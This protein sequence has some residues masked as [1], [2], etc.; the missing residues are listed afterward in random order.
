[1]PDSFLPAIGA[2]RS[3]AAA[4][5]GGHVTPVPASQRVATNHSA[6]LQEL[7]PLDLQDTKTDHRLTLVVVMYKI[8]RRGI[9]YTVTQKMFEEWLNDQY[10]K[11]QLA[12][13]AKQVLEESAKTSSEIMAVKKAFETIQEKGAHG[14]E[15]YAA[16]DYVSIQLSAQ[17]IDTSL[18]EFFE[19]IKDALSDSI[20]DIELGD[21]AAAATNVVDSIPYLGVITASVKMGVK[22]IQIGLLIKEA[23]K[24]DKMQVT[25]LS[26]LETE[27]LTAV[28]YFQKRAG[29]KLGKDFSFAGA[30]VITS[31]VGGGA[32]VASAHALV[33]FLMNVTIRIVDLLHAT[34][35]NDWLNKKNLDL[36][37][38][39][40]ASVLGLHIPHLPELSLLELTGL[41]P[42]GWKKSGEDLP[43]LKEAVAAAIK[44]Q[45]EAAQHWLTKGAIKWDKGNY[46]STLSNPPKPSGDQARDWQAKQWS[47]EYER[48]L[49]LYSV[50]DKYL[51]TQGLRLYKGRTLVHDPQETG[52]VAEIK[53]RTIDSLKNMLPSI[54]PK[55]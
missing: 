28:T 47:K 21:I 44:E 31:L 27:T 10:G 24:V 9:N 8:R 5:N 52:I 4:T 16:N 25:S 49:F 53:A 33:T 51:L 17:A 43:L 42:V 39:R 38:F 23:L 29:L 34:R 32:I 20:T 46:Q 36:D 13:G 18:G 1:M 45:G 11:T 40:S 12:S 54:S 14:G 26:V 55:S 50:T 19:A 37:K 6:A 48:I 3:S 15:S 2:K 41:L 22:G 35:A 7:P 30:G